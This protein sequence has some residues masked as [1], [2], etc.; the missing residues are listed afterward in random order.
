LIKAEQ[1][2]VTPQAEKLRRLTIPPARPLN[3]HQQQ[4][5]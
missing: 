3:S 2:G 1:N 5:R 4:L